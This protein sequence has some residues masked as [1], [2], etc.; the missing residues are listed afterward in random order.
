MTSEQYA[1]NV[2]DTLHRIFG[3]LMPQKRKGNGLTDYQNF[4]LN[5]PELCC[6]ALRRF[7]C[8]VAEGGRDP[9]FRHEEASLAFT[10]LAAAL[11]NQPIKTDMEAALSDLFISAV[12]EFE[13]K[14]DAN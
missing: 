1:E 2:A 7:L 9:Q 11:V 4:I 5:D 3:P 6:A 12:I 8:R 10:H 13:A 14:K